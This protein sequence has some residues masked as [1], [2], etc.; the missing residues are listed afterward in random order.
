MNA[1]TRCASLC[2]VLFVLLAGQ[3]AAQDRVVTGTVTAQN[4]GAALQGVNIV[5]QGTET[6][7]LTDVNGRYQL[8]VPENATLVFSMVGYA[9]REVPISDQAAISVALVVR[10][11]QLDELVVIGYG[12]Q[13]RAKLA[14]SVSKLDTATLRNVPYANAASSLQG[15]IAGLR[16][17]TTTGQPGAT[18]RVV[19]RGGTSIT[20]PNGATPLYIVDG[21]IRVN[22]DDLNPRDIESVQVLKDAA[23]TAIYG[24]RASNGVVIVTTRSRRAGEARLTYSSSVQV[25]DRPARMPLLSARDYIQYARL[26]VAATGEVDPARLAML[27]Q[28]FG[29]GTGND[30]TNR[31]GYTTQYLTPE[32]QHKLNEGWQS[33]PDPLD[34]SKTII[35]KETDWQD[36][37]FRRAVTHNHHV[38]V[39]G[40]SEEASYNLSVGYLKNEGTAITTGYRRLSLDMDGDVQVRDNLRV[41]GGL[42]FSNS[43]DNT[44]FSNFEIFQRSLALPPTAKLHYEDGTLAPGQNRSIGNPLYH[45]DRAKSRNS[46]DRLS[47]RLHGRWDIAPGLAFEPSASIYTTRGV[48]NFFQMSYFNTPTQFVDARDAEASH[49]L[50]WQRQADGVL[51]YNGAYL[52]SHN[53]EVKVGGSYYDRKNYSIDAEGRGAGSDLI[54]TLNAAA[55]PT[56]VSSSA[57]DLAIV[58]FFTRVNYDYDAKYLLSLTGRYDGASNLGLNNRW[59][60]FPGISAGWNLHLEPFWRS[61]P[62]A[63]SSL[64][65]RTSYGV[66]GNVSGLSDFHAQGEYTVGARYAGAAAILN[67]RLENPDLRWERSSTFGIGLDVGLLNDRTTLLLDVYRRVT[68]DLLTSLELPFSTGFQSVLTNFGSLENRGLELELVTEILQNPEGLN[69]TL[70]LNAA[71]NRNEIL[72]LPDNGNERNRIGGLQVY[73]PD[74]G[75]YV[76][77]GGLQEGG[78]LGDLYIWDQLGVYA[79]DEEAAQGPLDNLMPRTDKQKRAGDVIFADLDGNGVIDHRDQV[80]AGNIYPTWTGGFSNEFRFRNFGLTVRADFATGHTI[81][82]QSLL[83]YNGQTQGDITAT[84]EVLRSWQE[85][86]D[87]TDVPRYYWADQLAQNNIFRENRGTSYYYE[88]GDYLA[89]R[90]V[91]LSYAVPERWMGALGMASGRVYVTGNN[92]HYFTGYKGLLPE[93]GGTDSGRY[94]VMRNVLVGVNV[95]F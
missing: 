40:G 79:T 73:D 6:E 10:A 20:N 2:V 3:L 92:L 52:G 78:R 47:L 4:T 77:V 80:H 56:S 24:A 71:T 75:D 31:T 34:P 76:W 28:S 9:T 62:D 67:N 11:T 12:E 55:E 88:K 91:T 81:F 61:M 94:P 42:S 19:L 16:V 7:T 50:F 70:R 66:S 5:I 83:A 57:S 36:V 90:E 60:F 35:F 1:S 54:P 69:W 46:F 95:S 44:V 48:D 41:G 17:E 38:S 68:D 29:F 13:S 93:A 86:G 14:T 64:K 53:L 22:I 26:G 63:L 49:S 23:A 74:V 59:G 27:E 51:T 32:N 84:T 89:V 30:L 15:T 72:R 39:S 85:P 45:L 65:L 21:V 37:L 58:G 82:N 43:D 87:R 25:S 33:M 8:T 18:P